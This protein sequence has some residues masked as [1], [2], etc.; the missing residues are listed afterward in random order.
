MDFWLLA[1][2]IGTELYGEQKK[3]KPIHPIE[4]IHKSTIL[5][6]N[7]SCKPQI[8]FT[9]GRNKKPTWGI[10]KQDEIFLNLVRKKWQ[11]TE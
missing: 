2:S 1:V 9:S 7:S 5:K 3:K 10:E 11:W 8:Y 4:H 6:L